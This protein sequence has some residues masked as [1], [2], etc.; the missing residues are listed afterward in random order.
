MVPTK[1]DRI[2]NIRNHIFGFSERNGVTI[3]SEQEAFECLERGEFVVPEGEMQDL[4]EISEITVSHVKIAYEIDS[5][6]F[7]QPVYVFRV[8]I[9]QNEGETAEIKIPAIR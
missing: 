9:N 3:C 6:G 5:K 1:K 2:W 4:S 7:G 8:V